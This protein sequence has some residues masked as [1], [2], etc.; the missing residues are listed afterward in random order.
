MAS[1]PPAKKRKTHTSHADPIVLDEESGEEENLSL[2]EMPTDTEMVF[3]SI[4]RESQKLHGFVFLHQ[5]YT[6]LSDRTIVD[7]E[8]SDLRSKSKRL[9]VLN[10]TF[11]GGSASHT[12]T[13]TMVIMSTA[14]YVNSVRKYFA[15]EVAAARAS[16]NG[17]QA[18]H[19]CSKFSHW[20]RETNQ[21]S[22][23][24]SDLKRIAQSG[25]SGASGYSSSSS[26]SNISG[27]AMGPLSDAEIDHLLMCGFL[28]HRTSIQCDASE[29]DVDLSTN[30]LGSGV[31]VEVEVESARRYTRI[32]GDEEVY[33]LAH[34]ALRSL[35]L[36]MQAAEKEILAC[37]RKTR[38]RE[39]S[40]KK[41]AGLVALKDMGADR[42]GRGGRGGGGRGSGKGILQ[43]S[44]FPL[45]YHLKDL[46]GRNVL[47]K[48]AAPATSDYVLRI[49]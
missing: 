6:S 14:N 37:M 40:E 32:A 19:L 24:R 4:E 27:A 31:D 1:A 21:I 10:C 49:R 35:V 3:S 33:W 25:G 47:Y 23:L 12:R 38:Y 42:G 22:L 48:V 26:N 18:E 28:H 9:K 20:I 16:K 17:V 5:I 46:E 36:C 29:I 43:K 30:F 45:S 44:P 39:M 2:L 15:C 11:D 8:M 34:P 13:N 7:K 41:L